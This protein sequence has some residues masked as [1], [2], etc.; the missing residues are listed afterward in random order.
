MKLSKKNLIY[1]VMLAAVLMSLMIA[2]FVFML[3]SLYVDYMQSRNL[4]SIVAQHRAYLE[5]GDYSGVSVNNPVACFTVEIPFEEDC[6][7]FTNMA[8]KGR[9]EP[10]DDVLTEI[11]REIKE[12]I[13][14]FRENT[15]ELT[16]EAF[17]AELR[18]KLKQ[19]ERMLSRYEELIEELPFEFTL[20]QDQDYSGL[21]LS[22]SMKYHRI[23]ENLYVVEASVEDR[24]HQY[25]NYAAISVTENRFVMSYLPVMSPQMNEITPVVMQSIPMLSAVLLLLV[26]IFSRIYSKGIVTP[27]VK[28]AAQT[29]SL[30][31]EDVSSGTDCYMLPET[32]E[33]ACEEI[34]L[35]SDTISELYRGLQESC[36]LLQE[37]NLVLQEENERKEVFLRASSHQL[38]TPIAAALLLVD[39]MISRIGKYQDREVYLPQVKKQ[40]L[41]MKQIVEEVLYLN[42]C[43]EHMECVEV[44]L[45]SLLRAQLAAYEVIVREKSL[46]VR[47]LLKS[48]CPVLTDAGLMSRI[49]DNL[50]S[51]A[52]THTPE[53]E[54]VTV[55][56]GEKSIWIF[57]SGVQ[58]SEELLPHIFEPFVSGSH[59]GK[60]HGLGLYIAAYYAK[61]LDAELTI[62]NVTEGKPQL[63]G[64]HQSTA[65]Y[66][67][68]KNTFMTFVSEIESDVTGVCARLKFT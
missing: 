35:L 58:I 15:D 1:S 6:V 13:V 30:K 20:I 3:P 33:N 65:E 5:D 42:H 54:S 52:V 25:S 21:F 67:Q 46:V 24:N 37:Q 4:N 66:S 38:K 23:S 34:M 57:N 60:C 16:E 44:D 64:I 61:R 56:T 29:S 47:E 51:N 11:F 55:M 12:W 50:L 19:W 49:I 14:R 48:S 8:V 26:L 18:E 7:Y 10:K 28:L 40:L 32:P 53:G 27:I 39:G 36:R 63:S 43:E 68:I 45:R 2:Y 62:F 41:S 31:I 17:E 9:L 59:E 22:E